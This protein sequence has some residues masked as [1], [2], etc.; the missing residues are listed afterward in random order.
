[1]KNKEQSKAGID[2]QS[3]RTHAHDQQ[4][5]NQHQQ[6]KAMVPWP[7]SSHPL[8]LD[9]HGYCCTMEHGITQ[10]TRASYFGPPLKDQPTDLK[11]QEFLSII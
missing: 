2:I 4:V 11:R 8:P 6:N 5:L 9:E 7:P 1:M 10:L 3:A